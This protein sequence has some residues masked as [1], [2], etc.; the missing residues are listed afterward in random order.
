M[1]IAAGEKC[2]SR[3]GR[4]PT[5]EAIPADKRVHMGEGRYKL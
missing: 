4:A 2:H 3:D 1:F 5:L